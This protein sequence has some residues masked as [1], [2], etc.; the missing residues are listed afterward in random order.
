MEGHGGGGRLTLVRRP[1]LD[2]PGTAASCRSRRRGRRASCIGLPP[3]VER[4]PEPALFAHGVPGLAS[5][6]SG[7]AAAPDGSLLLSSNGEGTV[8][9][10][11]PIP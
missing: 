9:R 4:R 6:F 8:L 1:A 10:L 7:L 5:R 11:A 3:G 2:A